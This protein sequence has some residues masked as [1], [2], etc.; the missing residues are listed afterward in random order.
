MIVVCTSP[1]QS[2]S[3]PSSC[4]YRISYATHQV[5]VLHLFHHRNVVQ[6]DVEV[7]V[8]ALQ[9]A[10]HRDVVLEL[11]GDLMVHQ[12]LEE[13]AWC[14]S[15]WLARALNI[16]MHMRLSS[17]AVYARAGLGRRS[18]RLSAVASGFRWKLR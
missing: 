9:R 14:E 2:S 17:C 8:H 5:W 6:L 16:R 3:I 10:A 11:D 7:L 18:G 1:A 12:C 13:A 4:D 15:I